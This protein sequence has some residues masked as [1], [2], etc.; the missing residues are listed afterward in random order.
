M[1]INYTSE[2][3]NELDLYKL[4]EEFDWND[5]LKLDASQL[6]QAMKQS[7]LVIYAY[8]GDNL[9]GTG[10]IVSDGIINA[11]L[12]GLGVSTTYRK[13]GIGTEISRQLVEACKMKN[14]HIQ[15]FCEKHLVP[16]Y[17][18]QGFVKFAV[19]MMVK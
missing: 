17:E 9:V 6:N 15:F 2:L 18:K 19:G 4:Y 3:K 11:Y 8:D 16:Y 1:S 5:F 14:L 10:R 13:Q 12:C 7:W